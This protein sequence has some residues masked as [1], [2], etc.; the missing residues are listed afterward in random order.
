MF[1]LAQ[2]LGVAPSG[3]TRQYCLI[4]GNAAARWGW[5]VDRVHHTDDCDARELVARP[6]TLQSE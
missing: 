3:A 4:V 6:D 5:L 2:R 1:S